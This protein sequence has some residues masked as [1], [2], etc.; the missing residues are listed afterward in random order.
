[1]S[2]NSFIEQF[3]LYKKSEKHFKNDV[4]QFLTENNCIFTNAENDFIITNI[5][6]KFLMDFDDNQYYS[7]C[8]FYID[9]LNLKTKK[10][11]KNIL[12]SEDSLHYDLSIDNEEIFSD[13]WSWL[14][15]NIRLL[16][17]AF[18]NDVDKEII[19]KYKVIHNE[20]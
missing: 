20:S 17:S 13:V 8:E 15:D 3:K 16:S 6:L 7:N 1:M 12:F 9:L 11:Y 5:E 19:I 18:I 14:Y 2:L 10:K 4:I